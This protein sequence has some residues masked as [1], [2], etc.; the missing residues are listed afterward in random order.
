MKR[1]TASRSRKTDANKT[2]RRSAK[3]HAT[4]YKCRQCGLVEKLEDRFELNRQLPWLSSVPK[5]QLWAECPRSG[6]KQTELIDPDSP[7]TQRVRHC[8]PADGKMIRVCTPTVRKKGAARKGGTRIGGALLLHRIMCEWVVK[9]HLEEHGPE[10]LPRV[11][12]LWPLHLDAVVGVGWRPELVKRNGMWFMVAK[13]PESHVGEWGRKLIRGEEGPKLDN[14]W[15]WPE[16]IRSTSKLTAFTKRGATARR[17]S[18]IYL[19]ID[20][21]LPI[22]DQL[23]RLTPQV[24]EVQECALALCGR[25]KAYQLDFDALDRNAY[26]YFLS[27]KFGK[28]AREIAG[29]VFPDELEGA[30]HVRKVLSRFRQTMKNAAKEGR[31]I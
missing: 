4:P 2:A 19:P 3:G 10:E 31:D 13:Y 20:I 29:I 12:L 26:C 9:R 24:R 7:T 23:E 21:R 14:P 6:P 17:A 30:E 5:D 25:K 27:T 18:T 11:D 8:F 15:E 1:T 28:T 16:L 22:D